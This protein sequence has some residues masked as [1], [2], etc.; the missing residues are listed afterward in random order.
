[1]PKYLNLSAAVIA[2]SKDIMDTG[3]PPK[4]ETKEEDTDEQQ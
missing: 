3:T 1:M 2:K 4:E